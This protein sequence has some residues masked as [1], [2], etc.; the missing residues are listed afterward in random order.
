MKTKT[1]TI[2]AATKRLLSPPTA[3]ATVFAVSTAPPTTPPILE[4]EPE[5][6]AEPEVTYMTL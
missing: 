6:E 5:P 4:S 3:S 2:R 1:R